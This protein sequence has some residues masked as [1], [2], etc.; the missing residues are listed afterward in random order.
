MRTFCG[1]SLQ[2]SNACL[3]SPSEGDG[4]DGDRSR[5][6]W[7]AA[8][9]RPGDAGGVTAAHERPHCELSTGDKHPPGGPGLPNPQH[10]RAAPSRPT[11]STGIDLRCGAAGAGGVPVPC[12]MDV[13]IY[14]SLRARSTPHATALHTCYTRGHHRNGRPLAHRGQRGF[15]GCVVLTG[16]AAEVH[17]GATSPPPTAPIHP[18]KKNIVKKARPR[19]DRKLKFFAYTQWNVRSNCISISIST[20]IPTG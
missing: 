9:T 7:T 17:G 4:D 5:G 20:S 15:A 10:G 19:S 12:V 1:H 18:Y 16:V 3:S 6:A 2:N 8:R 14:S 11:E 13:I